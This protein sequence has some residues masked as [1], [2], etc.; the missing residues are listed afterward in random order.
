MFRARLNDTRS[1]ILFACIA[2]R[3]AA[4]IVSTTPPAIRSVLWTGE[5]SSRRAL[6]RPQSCAAA[7]RCTCSSPAADCAFGPR[8]RRLGHAGNP[9]GVYRGRPS[10]AAPEYR[11]LHAADPQLHAEAPDYRLPPRRSAST[12]W[13][14]IPAG[15]RGSPANTTSRSW[16]D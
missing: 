13:A 11:H 12:T 8:R 3:A 1:E 16:T 4:R 7:S 10:A 6:R 9:A 15:S 14:S 2:R 5:N